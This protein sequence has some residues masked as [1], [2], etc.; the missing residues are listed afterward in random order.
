MYAETTVYLY[1]GD[2]VYSFDVPSDDDITPGT[3][4]GGVSGDT[5]VFKINSLTADQ[6]GTW[7]SGTNVELNLTATSPVLVSTGDVIIAGFQSWNS[8]TGQSTAEYVSL[9]NTTDQTISLENMELISRVDT[10]SDG[11]VDVDWQLSAD[12]T[13][14]SIAPYSFFL[15]AEA[16]VAAPGGVHDLETEL[17]L[18]TGE[19]GV[20]ERAIG[21]ELLIDSVH[22]DYV[23]YGRHDGSTPAGEIPTGDITFDGSSWPRAEVIRNTRGTASFQDGVARRLSAEDLYAGYDVPGYYTDED[24]LGA[25]YPTGVWTSP[26]SDTFGAYEARNS[27]SPAVLPPAPPVCYALTVGHTGEGTTPSAS[28][29]NSTGCSAGEYVAGEAITLTGAVP[30]TGWQID[31]W[32]GTNGGNTFNMPAS[33]HSAGVNYTETPPTTMIC[34]SFDAYTPGSTIGTYPDWFDGGSGP[35]VTSGIGVASSIGLSSANPIFTWTAQPF[36]WMAPDFVGVNLQADFQTDGSGHFDDDRVGWMITDS[37]NGSDN[38]FGIQLDPGGSGP[39]G[40]N[41]EAYWDGD[42]F[43]DDGGRTSIANLPALSPNAWYRLRA[44]VVKLTDT[45]AMVT[46]SLTELDGSGNPGAVVASGSIADTALLP[47]TTGN[48][49]PNP[50]YFTGPIWPAYKNYNNISGAFDNP[51]YEV[52]TGTPPPEYTLTVVPPSNGSVELNPAGGTYY[53]GTTVTVTA[54]A[55]IGWGFQEWGDD[56]SGSSNPETIVMDANKTISATFYDMPPVALNVTIV[57]NGSV[58]LDPPGGSYEAG[59]EVELTATPDTGWYFTGWSG[60]LSGTASPTTLVMDTAKNVTATF[61][62]IPPQPSGICEDFETGFTLGQPVGTH[63][64]WFDSG[65]GPDSYFRQWLVELDR[66]GSRQFHLHLDGISLRLERSC[67]RK[68]HLR[69]GLPD[70]WQRSIR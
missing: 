8:V 26:H 59:T 30:D 54:V 23:L 36:D 15:I 57:G 55:D 69:Y 53:E 49:A 24:T 58:A 14:K 39:S 9:F 10:N 41:I 60:A 37:S 16:G 47:G 12:L 61:A 22:M 33:G 27:T 66:S 34:E 7:A 45:S 68:H 17:D 43:G 21:L 29:A 13:G 62:E 4:E 42:S 44:E 35:V 64:E 3:I 51:C 63:A 5:I 65:S 25:G 52:V 31:S 48:E 20:A 67:L 28:P 38:I 11:V 50:G 32:Y 1:E 46:A 70:R 18:A 6:Q 19:G 40:Y 56:L 2:T